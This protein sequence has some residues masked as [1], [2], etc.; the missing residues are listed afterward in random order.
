[1]LALGCAASLCG[2]GTLGAAERAGQISAQDL[3]K[4]ARVGIEVAQQLVPAFASLSSHPKVP[5]EGGVY[6][7]RLY[8]DP[9]QESRVSDNFDNFDSQKTFHAFLV[10]VRPED[11]SRVKLTIMADKPGR[12]D[13]PRSNAFGHGEN[14]AISRKA[15]D[16][17]ENG[18]Y[19]AR[20]DFPGGRVEFFRR[21]PQATL[22]LQ[23]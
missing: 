15:P 8:F 1:M 4:M 2:A 6:K 17:P 12:R 14:V 13:R 7:L 19:V 3:A 10:N 20:L 18:N 16:N 5:P 21:N 9:G 23:P 11:L 22:L